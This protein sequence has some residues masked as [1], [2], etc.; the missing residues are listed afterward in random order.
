MRD[1][2]AFGFAIGVGVMLVLN[3]AI[4]VFLYWRL[5]TWDEP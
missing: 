5:R 2:F 4:N 3:L 1:E